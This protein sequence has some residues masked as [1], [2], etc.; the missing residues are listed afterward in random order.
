[1][2]DALRA[3]GL[4]GHN[5]GHEEIVAAKDTLRQGGCAEGG[6]R[7]LPLLSSLGSSRARRPL[8]PERP[9]HLSSWHR[10][11]TEPPEV[12]SG[13]RAEV[14]RPG[15]LWLTGDGALPCSMQSMSARR[16]VRSSHGARTCEPAWQGTVVGQASVYETT[17]RVDFKLTHY[18]RDRR[19]G[20]FHVQKSWRRR[21]GRQRES[22][23]C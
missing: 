8:R 10:T 5:I 15:G 16:A 6:C 9:R 3:G 14:I 13:N 19:P 2:R 17:D 11:V 1:M 18:P 12:T 22:E 7:S 20:G 4:L 21:P 23:V